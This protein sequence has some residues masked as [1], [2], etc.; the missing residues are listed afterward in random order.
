MAPS[1]QISFVRPKTGAERDKEE[2]KE[3]KEDEGDGEEGK[4]VFGR[5]VGGRKKQTTSLFGGFSFGGGARSA[6]ASDVKKWTGNVT[7]PEMDS[8]MMREDLPFFSLR[9][10]GTPFSYKADPED[11]PCLSLKAEATAVVEAHF[12]EAVMSGKKALRDRLAS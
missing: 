3:R 5:A 12:L 9:D 8:R 6:S 1:L 7:V 10:D 2:M 11:G 4:S